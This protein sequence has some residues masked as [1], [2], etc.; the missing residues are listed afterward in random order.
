MLLNRPLFA[1]LLI[2]TSVSTTAATPP[3]PV[4]ITAANWEASVKSADAAYWAAYNRA[5]HAALN[6]F[7]DDDVEFYHDRGGKLIGKAALSAV[8]ASPPK[9]GTRLRR[10][11]VAGTVHFYPMREGEVF[12]GAVV[13]GEHR[14][15][16]TPPGKPE[17]AVGRSY[18][19]QLMVLRGNEWKL[20]RILSY[21]HVD[22][23]KPR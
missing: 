21:E 9:D 22:T 23:G 18:F 12:Y 4:S 8:N 19:T 20:S 14:F 13:S 1:A 6:A 2:A 11:A 3:V 16:A 15:F 5:D 10:E 7:L 17:I